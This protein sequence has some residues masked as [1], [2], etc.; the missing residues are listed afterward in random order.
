[1][2]NISNNYCKCL[3]RFGGN[4]IIFWKCQFFFI[5]I[6]YLE[7]QVLG[8]YKGGKNIYKCQPENCTIKWQWQYFLFCNNVMPFYFILL[9]FVVY[10]VFT[11]HNIMWLQFW[12]CFFHHDMT[13]LN[14]FMRRHEILG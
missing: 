8:I 6:I 10:I 13:I 3:F 9:Y 14:P 4:S 2:S 5:E 7:C 11:P 12:T 1:M